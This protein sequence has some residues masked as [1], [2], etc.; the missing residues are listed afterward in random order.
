MNFLQWTGSALLSEIFSHNFGAS[1]SKTPLPV[2]IDILVFLFGE[3][4]EGIMEY[5]FHIDV[6]VACIFLV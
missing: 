4:S 6:Y 2:Q 1:Y 5:Y 3:Q